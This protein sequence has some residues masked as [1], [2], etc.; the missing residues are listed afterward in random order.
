MI[1]DER[2]KLGPVVEV[3]ESYIGGPEEGRPG[4]GAEK[5]ILAVVAAELSSDHKKIGRIRLASANDASAGSLIPFVTKNVEIGSTVVTD[6]WR[7]Y[8]STSR[9]GLFP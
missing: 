9:R 5:K 4:R 3:D 1:R 7:G 8:A 2:E 6:G